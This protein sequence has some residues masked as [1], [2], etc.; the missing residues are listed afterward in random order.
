MPIHD[1]PRHAADD[2]SDQAVRLERLAAA[3]DVFLEFRGTGIAATGSGTAVVGAAALENSGAAADGLLAHHAD[4]RDLLEPMLAAD[5]L[6]VTEGSE[7]KVAAPHVPLPGQCLGDYRI[8]REIGRGGM[9]TVF[10]AEQVSLRRRVALKLLHEHLTWSPKAVERFRREAAAASGLTHPGIVPIHEVGEWRGRHYF[11][12]EFLEGRPLQDAMRQPRLGVRGDCSRAAECAELVARVADALQHAHSN[13]L[14][15]RDVKPHNIMVGA[16]GSVRLLDF[17]L[18]K[19]LHLGAE[20][21]TG[22]FLGTPYYS[23]PEQ[24]RGETTG[25]QSDV[26][27]LGVVLY[28]L[29]SGDRPFRGDT[30][31]EV[32]HRIELGDFEPLARTAPNA[33]RDLRTICEKAM[34]FAPA[35]RYASAA[36]MAADLRRFLRIEPILATP[37]ST[38]IRCGKW[39]RRHRFGVA[40]WSAIGLIVIGGPVAYGA[41]EYRTR[42]AVE[43]EREH[44]VEAEQLAFKSIVQTLNMLADDLARQPGSSRRKLPRIDRVVKLCEEFLEMGAADPARCLQ[45]AHAYCVIAGIHLQLD[46]PNGALAATARV[47][48]LIAAGDA[49]RRVGPG[50][51]DQREGEP[52]DLLQGHLLRLEMRAR[53]ALDRNGGEAEFERA[54]AH[55]RDL[56]DRADATPAS[57]V[58]YAQTLVSRARTIEGLPQRLPEGEKLL[59]EALAVLGPELCESNAVAETTRISAMC[60]LGC[61]QLFGGS[62]RAAVE[63]LE[64]VVASTEDAAL[65]PV[66]GIE[67]TVA[68]AGL[69]DAFHRLGEDARALAFLQRSVET[70]A[71]LVAEYPG[72]PNL[73]RAVQRSRLRLSTLQL[74]RGNAKAAEALLRTAASGLVRG[75]DASCP[76]RALQADIDSQLASCILMQRGGNDPEARALLDG[77]CELLQALVREQPGDLALRL[78]LGGVYNNLAAL[79]NDDGEYAA[80]RQFAENAIATQRVVIAGEPENR[81]A[82]QFMGMHHSQLALALAQLGESAAAVEAAKTTA[83]YASHHGATMRIAAEAATIAARAADNEDYGRVAVAALACIANADRDEA[84]RWLANERF[85]FLRDRADFTELRTTL[86]MR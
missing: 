50:S 33:P 39:V 40:L 45:V 17:G 55:W 3:M 86:G 62:P 5:G 66:R 15:H 85:A 42:V 47:R 67:R 68:I 69:G 31:R 65:D 43:T 12:M 37:P 29:L 18:V 32:L 75:A 77:A 28:E 36:A 57:I 10:E 41:H 27:S 34:E 60:G 81:R 84:R 83:L 9:G 78:D 72:V 38:M 26:F 53:I 63:A 52:R 6:T 70:G 76:D 22:E 24:A 13:G 73:V 64:D 8:A 71:E 44:L 19:Q 25:P 49:A 7:T 2:S 58:E 74:K 54:I 1:D 14:I 56:I 79:A 59:R 80:A 48:K 20:S 4:L 35:E 30:A 21:V 11:T 82:R 16:D 61:V 23:S 51:G 46:D